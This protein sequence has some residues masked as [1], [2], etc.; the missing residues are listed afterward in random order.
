MKS[1]KDG[2]VL[3]VVV[4]LDKLPTA[5][6]DEYYSQKNCDRLG[7]TPRM[8]LE[9]LRRSDAPKV[10]RIG[11]LRLV[12]REDMLEFMRRVG[13]QNAA[14]RVREPE[15]ALDEADRVLLDW[16]CAPQPKR[17]KTG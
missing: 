16:G 8:F 14:A 13:E 1:T 10:M 15:G 2:I 11:K 9:L 12:P 5:A 6:P 4:P 17:R 7:I 3:E